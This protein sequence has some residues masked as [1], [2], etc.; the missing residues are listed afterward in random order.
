MF[1]IGSDIATSLSPG[2]IPA[3]SGSDPGATRSTTCTTSSRGEPGTVLGAKVGTGNRGLDER[4]AHQ[5][6]A[7]ARPDFSEADAALNGIRPQRY[8]GLQEN[9]DH[10]PARRMSGTE[11]REEVD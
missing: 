9:N 8:P 1:L 11:F 3:S 4:R 2:A 6:S 7:A 5:D 10:R